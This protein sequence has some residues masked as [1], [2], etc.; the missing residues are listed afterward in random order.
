MGDE[1]GKASEGDSH[2]EMENVPQVEGRASAKALRLELGVSE[3]GKVYIVGVWKGRGPGEER[4]HDLEFGVLCG[5]RVP[6]QI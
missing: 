4:G 6:R 2:A 3:A 5:M 1:S